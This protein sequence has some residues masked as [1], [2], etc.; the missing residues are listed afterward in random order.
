M[1]IRISTNS[2]PLLSKIAKLK[3]H[4]NMN[5]VPRIEKILGNVIQQTKSVITS[6]A[7]AET[8]ESANAHLAQI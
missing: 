2:F 1:N 7:L 4:W 5:L 8:F 3:G 6:L